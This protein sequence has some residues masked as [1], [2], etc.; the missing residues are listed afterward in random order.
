[1]HIE[2]RA[3]RATFVP[4]RQEPK[5]Q[6]QIRSRTANAKML[7]AR[8]EFWSIR[9]PNFLNQFQQKPRRS[10][11]GSHFEGGRSDS[12][13]DRATAARTARARA[14]PK[15]AAPGPRYKS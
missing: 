7:F 15:V 14:S 9:H 11:P 4:R 5:E 2:H 3:P 8:I 13:K 6:R 12:R 1:M 10:V